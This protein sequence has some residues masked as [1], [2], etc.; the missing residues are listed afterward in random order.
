MKTIIT[1]LLAFIT[2]SL[3][4]QKG[5]KPLT[6]KPLTGNFY[7][8][9]TYSLY[10]GVPVPANAMYLVTDDGVILF[11]TPWDSTQF[12]PLLDSIEAKHHKKV[13]A[14]IATH[15]HEDRTGGFDYYNSKG[16][17]TYATIQTDEQC[18]LK[19][20]KRARY[21]LGS[22]TAFT[23]GGYRFETYYP[24]R[25]HAPDN[26]VLWF[27]A[28]KIL[29]GG[30]FI[31]STDARDLGYTGDADVKEWPV[32]VKRVQDKFGKPQYVIPGHGNWRNK[33]SPEHT[34]RLLRKHG[35]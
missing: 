3:F 9:I 24:G 8:Y 32:A 4:A 29:Y 10:K 27:P 22:D 30:C 28:E 6:I 2:V 20:E 34:L 33:K 15:S 14:C 26:I 7:V 31:K 23:I 17:K 25:G 35:N 5:P 19:N 13:I 11:D 18:K 16:I 1:V 21:L 12:Q